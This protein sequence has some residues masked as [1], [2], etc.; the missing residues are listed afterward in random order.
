MPLELQ[1]F[2][3]GEFVRVG[4]R[5]QFDL[6]AS[7]AALAELIRA[8]KRRGLHRALLDVRDA[9]ANLNPTELASIVNTFRE[10][11]FTHDQCLAIVHS[12]DPHHRARTF[13][14]ISR[15]RGWTVQAFGDFDEAVRWLSSIQSPARKASEPAKRIPVAGLGAGRKRAARPKKRKYP[16][17]EE[18]PRLTRS[19]RFE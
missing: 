1:V 17:H 3:A 10:I 6:A 4:G 11:G 15:M 14:F 7:C 5:G 9:Q 16:R 13:A 8:C 19:S 12:G 2:H 18:T